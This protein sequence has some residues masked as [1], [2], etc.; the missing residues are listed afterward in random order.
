MMQVKQSMSVGSF[1]LLTF[2]WTVLVLDIVELVCCVNRYELP[3]DRHDCTV[4]RC[5][6]CVQYLI[7]YYD[8]DAVYPNP[9]Y[10]YFT[11]LDLRSACGLMDGTKLGCHGGCTNCNKLNFWAVEQYCDVGIITVIHFY[12]FLSHMHALQMFC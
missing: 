5:S 8:D 9:Y 1:I 4:D 6:K 10:Q 2:S 3:F 12:F 7:D 11:V